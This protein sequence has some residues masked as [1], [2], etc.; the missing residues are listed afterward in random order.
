MG[1]HPAHPLLRNLEWQW[2]DI[3]SATGYLQQYGFP[4]AV[5][6]VGQPYVQVE[7]IS[8][9]HNEKVNLRSG[10]YS[11]GI[12]FGGAAKAMMRGQSRAQVRKQIDA[13]QRDR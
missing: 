10:I 7:E 5:L 12:L 8:G 3:P 2:I 13:T 9:F 4:R 6:T 1:R 11:L